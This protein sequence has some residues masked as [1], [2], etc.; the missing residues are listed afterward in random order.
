MTPPRMPRRGL[1]QDPTTAALVR[2]AR[3]TARG[4]GLSRRSLLG[5]ALLGGGAAALT[6]CAPPEPPA[7]GVQALTL[8]KDL[9]ATEKVV[10]W[11]NWTA[12]LLS[13]IHI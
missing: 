4:S 10:R 12:Y 6:G 11:A 2:A 9:S 5:T 7:G 8:P 3:S 13:L 1:P